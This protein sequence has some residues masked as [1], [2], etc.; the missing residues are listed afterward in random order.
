MVKEAEEAK[1]EEELAVEG[2]EEEETRRKRVCC[3]R[4][5]R[6]R[7]FPHSVPLSTMRRTVSL[8]RPWML[9]AAST[10][11][12]V[13]HGVLSQSAQDPRLLLLHRVLPC[14]SACSGKSAWAMKMW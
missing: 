11:W 2:E 14:A 5:T 1:A 9:P 6:Y 7:T 8:W 4:S 3:S 10:S 12:A 13:L